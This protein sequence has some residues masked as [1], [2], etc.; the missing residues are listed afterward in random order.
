[1]VNAIASMFNE[2]SSCILVGNKRSPV[3]N[4]SAG[5]LQGS[6]LSPL[7][8]AFFINSLAE[9]LRKVDPEPM[10]LATGLRVNCLLYADDIVLFSHKAEILRTLLQVCD[11]HAVCR[12]YVFGPSKC[13]IIE[14]ITS[15]EQY[16]L[17][18]VEIQKDLV[19]KFLGVMITKDDISAR[20]HVADRSAKMLGMTQFFSHMGGVEPYNGA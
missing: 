18:G 1:M 8:Y 11:Q 5:L 7:L 12:N 13:V 19:F 10:V 6:S 16:A 3:F 2:C 14:P 15:E 17:H 9:E 4:N 20:R